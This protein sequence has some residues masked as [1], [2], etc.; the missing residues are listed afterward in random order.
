MQAQLRDAVAPRVIQA[1]AVEGP[2]V[3][4][5]RLDQIKAE[6]RVISGTPLRSEDDRLRRQALWQ[7]LDQ[8]IAVGPESGEGAS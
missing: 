1:P 5:M 4:T 6:L 7:R 3:E 8:L 2:P